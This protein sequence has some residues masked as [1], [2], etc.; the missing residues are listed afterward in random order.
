MGAVLKELQSIVTW[1]AYL[2][3]TVAIP[4]FYFVAVDKNTFESWVLF[5]LSIV[6]LIM[7]IIEDFRKFKFNK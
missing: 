7:L 2:P 4:L 6:G 3:F 5:C 1:L